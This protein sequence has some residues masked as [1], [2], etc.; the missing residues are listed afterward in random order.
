[1]YE[2]KYYIVFDI[3]RNFRPYQSHAPTEIVDIGAIKIEAGTMS[4]IEVFSS[5]VKPTA[6][7][8]RHTTKLTGIT[9]QDLKGVEKFPYVM[10]RFREFVGEDYMLV[11]WGREDYGFLTQDCEF[12]NVECPCLEKERRF[13]LQRFVLQAYTEVFQSHPSLM[14]AVTQFD[15]EWEGTQHRAFA[16]AKNTANL[17]LTVAKQKDI[18]KRY[19]RNIELVLVNNGSLTDKGKKKMKR[20]VFKELK[21][22]EDMQLT[23][24][25]FIK[26]GTWEN[27][28]DQ[29]DFD[30]TTMQLLQGY[31][32]TALKKAKQQLQVLAAMN[33][34]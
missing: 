2:P 19:K 13:D 21:K 1:M 4:I 22:N 18:R 23:W 29:Y 11:T 30:N 27:V 32:K 8:S 7:L 14:S 15:L 5:L 3:E 6:S 20:W 25:M 33:N 28:S 31:F 17:F 12:H 9:K 16:D 34:Q 10:E 24:D 26:S